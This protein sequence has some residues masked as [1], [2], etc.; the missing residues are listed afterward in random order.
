MKITKCA[1]LIYF[2]ISEI[3]FMQIIK[4]ATSKYLDL[5]LNT[6]FMIKCLDG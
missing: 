3:K 1:I 5:F 4:F 2:S 6:A